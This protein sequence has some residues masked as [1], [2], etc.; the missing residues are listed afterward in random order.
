MAEEVKKTS[1]RPKKAVEDKVVEG[2]IIVDT[3][4]EDLKAKNDEM[5]EMLKMMQEQMAQMQA[6]IS[7][8]NAPIEIKREKTKKVKVINL[9]NMQ[10]NLSTEGFGNG[11]H[12]HFDNF[13]SM[14]TMSVN[15]LEEILSIGAQRKQAEEGFFY[16][17]DSEVVEDMDLTDAYEVI[18]DKKTIEYIVGLSEDSCVEM[19]CGLSDAMKESTATLM[20]EKINNGKALDRNRLA[21]IQRRTEIN[22]EEIAKSLKEIAE[23]ASI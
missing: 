8:S 22:I 14:V 11:K 21:D 16:I 3:E 9:L 7:N 2:N 5:A 15:Y 20:A 23:R 19:F 12:F 18:H 4:K 13:G 10:L 6:Q 17:C 1:G